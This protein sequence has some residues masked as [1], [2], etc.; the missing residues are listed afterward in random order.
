MVRVCVC[1]CE[2]ECVCECVVVEECVRICDIFLTR[3]LDNGISI[4]FFT[5]NSITIHSFGT[6]LFDRGGEPS[7]HNLLTPTNNRIN[8]RTSLT[9][10]A[11]PLC[12][13]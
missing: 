8:E 12:T 4:V 7:V 13:A 10:E 9:E 1:V 11:S 5:I 2:C 6:H 3:A